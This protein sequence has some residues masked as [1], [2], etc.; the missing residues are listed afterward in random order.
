MRKTRYTI[1]CENTKGT[2]LASSRS[3][4]GLRDTAVLRNLGQVPR[5]VE[6]VQ[7]GTCHQGLILEMAEYVIPLADANPLARG[8]PARRRLTG[9]DFGSWLISENPGVISL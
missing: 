5:V 4:Y 9:K 1:N 7:P 6:P 8:P 3:I 2:L